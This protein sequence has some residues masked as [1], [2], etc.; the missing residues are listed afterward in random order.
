MA[1]SKVAASA[2]LTLK[3]QTGV[4]AAGQ[5]VYRARTFRNLKPAA[6]D[7]DVYDIGAAVGA[8]QAHPVAAVSRVDTGNL[9][10]G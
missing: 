8:L 3:V 6:T 9:V 2:E 7:A 1:V 10:N 4:N 5:P